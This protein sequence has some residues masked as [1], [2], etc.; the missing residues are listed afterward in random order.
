MHKSARNIN[1]TRSAKTR[2]KMRIHKK[3]THR[4]G[5]IL[6]KANKTLKAIKGGSSDN[7]AISD[8]QIHRAIE[9]IILPTNNFK[10]NFNDICR[11]NNDIKF[12]FQNSN[13]CEIAGVNQLNRVAVLKSLYKF[14]KL[15]NDSNNWNDIDDSQIEQKSNELADYRCGNYPTKQDH[16][17]ILEDI[18]AK[19]TRDNTQISSVIDGLMNSI[20]EELL[21]TYP[22][23]D[24]TKSKIRDISKN[25][26]TRIFRIYF[27]LEKYND[28]DLIY[29]LFNLIELLNFFTNEN[30]RQPSDKNKNIISGIAEIFIKLATKFIENEISH[31]NSELPMTGGAMTGKEIAINAGIIIVCGVIIVGILAACI[32]FNI[33]IDPSIFWYRRRYT[34]VNII[35]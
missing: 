25:V 26:T 11:N 4:K 27:G 6:R 21:T 19:I 34:Q 33:K 35:F 31:S 22:I 2:P 28:C 10:E 13:Y 24:E 8:E 18:V 17:T 16:I 20:P 5:I 30:K 3:R 9:E 32:Y 12:L 15:Y 23:S 29:K 14:I 1:N 7:D